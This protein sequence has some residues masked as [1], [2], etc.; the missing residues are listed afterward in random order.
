MTSTS[1]PR[2]LAHGVD[3]LGAVGRDPQPGRPDRGD[4]LDPVRA[5]PRRPSPA[6]ASTVRSIGSSA[7]AAGLVE[8]FAEPRDLGA[9]DDRP[10]LAVGRALADV[11]LDGVRADVDDRVTASHRSPTS[12]LSPRA[13]LTFGRASRPSSR[14]AAITRLGI[15]RL[16][17]DRA[18]SRPRLGAHLGQLRHAAADRVV[19]APLV[20]LDR[21]RAR[22]RLD[23]LV[24]ELVERVLAAR[25]RRGRRRRAPRSTAT[26]SAGESGKA[27]FSTGFHC[28][29]PSSFTARSCLTSISPSRTLT[30]AS[31]PS[32]SR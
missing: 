32:E 5:A 7:E 30:E 22:G 13:R 26:T 8:T 23:D 19:L 9:V 4:R 2:A 20:H 6:I 10:P 25:K 11:E 16:D 29:S 28:S 24:D 31:L 1:T 3:E 14:T 21:A 17:G 18:S 15:L 27:A 12:A